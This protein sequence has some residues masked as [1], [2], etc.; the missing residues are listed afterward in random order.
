MP[1]PDGTRVTV[2]IG[3]TPFKHFP[4]MDVSILSV[5]GQVLRTSSVVG[6]IER[7]FCLLVGFTHADTAA[8]VDWMAENQMEVI[9][10]F[11]HVIKNL[12][13]VIRSR[14]PRESPRCRS[15]MAIRA[16]GRSARSSRCIPARGTAS[17]CIP[18]ACPGTCSTSPTRT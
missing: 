8:E 12:R 2:E 9:Y 4:A 10:D 3:L 5:E 17:S 13:V 7:G 16:S 14:V 6:A 11:F 1:W 15:E 18:I